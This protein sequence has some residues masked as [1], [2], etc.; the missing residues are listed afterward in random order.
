MT[1]KAEKYAAEE[2]SK[3]YQVELASV[4]KQYDTAEKA[5]DKAN[6][7]IAKSKTLKNLQSV[8]DDHQREMEE[9]RSQNITYVISLA[10]QTKSNDALKAECDRFKG[11]LASS[12]AQIASAGVQESQVE[13]EKVGGKRGCTNLGMCGLSCACA[14]IRG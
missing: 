12:A 6:K 11:Q 7:V 5:L 14:H 4:H 9:L 3:R 10:D 8:L 1:F 13:E 2:Q